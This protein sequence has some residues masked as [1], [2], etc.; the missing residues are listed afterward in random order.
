M[1]FGTYKISLKVDK[2]FEISI[3]FSTLKILF[4]GTHMAENEKYLFILN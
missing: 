1:C 2:W 3:C 4:K